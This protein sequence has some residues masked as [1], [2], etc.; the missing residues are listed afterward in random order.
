MV[1]RHQHHYEAP[2]EINGIE[3]RDLAM[4]QGWGGRPVRVEQAQGILVA[5]LG[6][7]VG[8]YGYEA[9]GVARRT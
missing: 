5:A 1:K 9:D 4:R 6:V 7:L 2:Q 8:Y 3:P